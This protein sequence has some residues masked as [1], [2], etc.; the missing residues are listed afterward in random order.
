MPKI[1]I[2]GPKNVHFNK[3]TRWSCCRW[4]LGPSLRTTGPVGSRLGDLVLFRAMCPQIQLS[5]RHM[6]L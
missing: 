3:H 5:P 2:W 6:E 4:S 1:L